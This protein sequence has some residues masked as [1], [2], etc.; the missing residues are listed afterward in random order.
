[1]EQE[2]K[3]WPQNKIGCFAIKICMN[4]FTLTNNGNLYKDDHIYT[5]INKTVYLYWEKKT[6][7]TYT[8]IINI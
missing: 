3:A 5:E 1:L 8:E 4:M 7:C 2:N 6:V